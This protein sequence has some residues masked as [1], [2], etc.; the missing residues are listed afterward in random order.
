MN[1]IMF[2]NLIIR[3]R[4]GIV[5]KG[6]VKSISSLNDK[7]PFDI[8]PMHTNFVSVISDRI[9]VV[10]ENGGINNISITRGIIRVKENTAD[11]YL[12]I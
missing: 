2:L 8:L 5:F 1:K 12:G 9:T 10:A 11:V 6:L 7:G 4:D 3:K